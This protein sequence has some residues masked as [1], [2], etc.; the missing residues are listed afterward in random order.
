MTSA[1]KVELLEWYRANNHAFVLLLIS[2]RFDEHDKDL[3]DN[4]V[5]RMKGAA[6]AAQ[7]LAR[8]VIIEARGSVRR[9]V[10]CTGLPM[11]LKHRGSALASKE[12]WRANAFRAGVFTPLAHGEEAL[13]PDVLHAKECSDCGAVAFMYVFITACYGLFGEEM[14]SLRF[15]EPIIS[16]WFKSRPEDRGS[17]KD[18]VQ[19][20]LNKHSYL[21]ARFV[22]QFVD[23]V[24]SV[25]YSKTS[26]SDSET[27]ES[28]ASRVVQWWGCLQHVLDSEHANWPN[29]GSPVVDSDKEAVLH[30]MVKGLLANPV[31][32]SGTLVAGLTLALTKLRV[33]PSVDVFCSLFMSGVGHIVGA[34]AD[35]RLL[36][37]QANCVECLVF[38]ALIG[39][40]GEAMS[41]PE[42]SVSG[43]VSDMH[44]MHPVYR[45]A[46]WVQYMYAEYGAGCRAAT[47][48]SLESSSYVSTEVPDLALHPILWP[49]D[50]TLLRDRGSDRDVT[51]AEGAKKPWEIVFD[52][53]LK[54]FKQGLSVID[55]PLR[56]PQVMLTAGSLET[57]EVSA[58]LPQFNG[59]IPTSFTL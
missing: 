20:L 42:F 44:R 25:L 29:D 18:L 7:T 39:D 21:P 28:V 11:V 43:L 34:Y 10:M 12:G 1:L 49:S 52:E 48:G 4:K 35:S 41:Y 33:H 3:F 19:A 8:G 38:A 57:C 46:H 53:T 40:D 45:L 58:L 16:T 17:T 15:T 36:S 55:M 59:R 22:H 31:A 9:S 32:D 47:L 2:N 13:R 5:A 50:G 24:K 54:K 51:S 23:T 27:S 56:F 30:A 14:L 37:R 26:E 6:D